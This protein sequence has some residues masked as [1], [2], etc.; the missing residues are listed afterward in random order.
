L[1]GRGSVIASMIREPAAIPAPPEIAADNVAADNAAQLAGAN[2]MYTLINE[3]LARLAEGKYTE[4]E[5]MD[6]ASDPVAREI[7]AFE[8]KYDLLAC[9]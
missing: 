3:I 1:R 4:A 9:P 8:S 7:E 5:A 6:L 2:S